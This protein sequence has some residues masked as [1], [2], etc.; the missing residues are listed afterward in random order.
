MLSGQTVTGTFQT[1]DA[2]TA[3]ADGEIK[4]RYAGTENLQ[5]NDFTLSSE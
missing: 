4:L 1:T 5:L 3:T 2:D